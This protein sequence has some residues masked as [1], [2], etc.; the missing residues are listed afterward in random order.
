MTEITGELVAA[1]AVSIDAV[2]EIGRQSGMEYRFTMVVTDSS[3]QHVGDAVFDNVARK[4]TFRL[5]N[6][7]G[8]PT[9]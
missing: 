2:K 4:A 1:I 7:Y 8:V 3:G 9:W 5:N 6:D